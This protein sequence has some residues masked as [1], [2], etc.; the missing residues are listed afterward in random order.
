VKSSIRKFPENVA[1]MS[2]L[3]LDRIAWGSII[4]MDEQLR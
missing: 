2:R 1:D 4:D 3:T